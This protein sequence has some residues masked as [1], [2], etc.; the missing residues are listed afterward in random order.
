MNLGG[1]DLI[2]IF[3]SQSLYNFKWVQIDE[4]VS[5]TSIKSKS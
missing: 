2:I 1:P 3:L 5:I 4:Y